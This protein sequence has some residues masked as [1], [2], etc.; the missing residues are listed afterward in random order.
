M[1]SNSIR[2][3]RRGVS[4]LKKQGLLPARSDAGLKIDARSAIPEI[5]V[6]GKKLSTLIRK[7]DSIVSGKATALKVPPATLTKYRKSGFA[8]TQGR[9]IVP[10]AATEKARI[11][12]GHVAIKSS[13]GIERVQIPVEFHNLRQYLRDMRKNAAVINRLK[14][15]REYFGIRFYGGQR[16]NFYSDIQAL[17]DDLSRY[18][19]FANVAA[20]ALAYKQEEIYHHL[21]ILRMTRTGALHVEQLV[22][23]RKRT[24]TKEYNRKH[25]K[26]QRA[27]IKRNPNKLKISNTQNAARQKAYRDRVKKH[28]K[29]A[30]KLKRAAKKRQKKYRDSLR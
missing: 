10:H 15:P 26:K 16:A 28:P 7:Y 6:K 2:E 22:S 8:T 13:K 11:S 4:L 23:E 21:E 14:G 25:A 1:A 20:R 5:K 29:Q 27:K 3:F 12:K 24:M 30:A 17:L 19:S 9:V 18:D